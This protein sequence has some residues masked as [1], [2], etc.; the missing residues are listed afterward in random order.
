M[1]RKTVAPLYPL[2]DFKTLYKY[3]IIIITYNRISW[4][5]VTTANVLQPTGKTTSRN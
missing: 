4:L 2:Q 1:D 3:C 5:S